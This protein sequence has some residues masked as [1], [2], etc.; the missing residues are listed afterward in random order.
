MLSR[1]KIGTRARLWRSQAI[2]RS[3]AHRLSFCHGVLCGS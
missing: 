2:G 1:A 3:P